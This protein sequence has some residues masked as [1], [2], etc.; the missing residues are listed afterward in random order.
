MQNIVVTGG[1]CFI[2]SHFIAALDPN[3]FHVIVID[4]FSNSSPEILE[5]LQQISLIKIDI[6]DIDITDQA[7]LSKVFKRFNVDSVVHFAGLKSVEESHKNPD[8]YYYNNV[9]GTLNIL[10]LMKQY[11]IKSF[12]FSSSA[13]VYGNSSIQ[14]VS[15]EMAMVATNPYGSTKIMVEQILKDFQK[16]NDSVCT[17]SLRYFNPIGAHIS[18]KMGE[19]PLGKPNNLMPIIMGAASGRVKALTIFGNDYN[20]IDGTGVRDY[21]HVMDLADAHLAALSFSE[22][23]TGN[24]FFNIGTGKPT[25]VLQLIASFE[26][27]TGVNVPYEIKPRRIGDVDTSFADTKKVEQMLG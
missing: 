11:N 10:S 13:T 17:I 24:F 1:C 14:P 6:F 27:V 26:K 12:V 8:K 25:S 5:R 3:K 7:S 23:N 4:N 22:G 2:G 19:N 18:G 9:A 20:T 16:A 15:A 21:I